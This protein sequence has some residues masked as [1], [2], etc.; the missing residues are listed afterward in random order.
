MANRRRPQAVVASLNALSQSLDAPTPGTDVISINRRRE[1]GFSL[2]ELLVIMSVIMIIGMI[3]VSQ[4]IMAYDRSRQRSTLADLR[5]LA[6][7]N[8]TY[9]VD[10]GNYAPTLSDVEPDY[11]DPAPPLDRWGFAWDYTYS[12]GK[13]SLRSHGSD[14]AAGPAPPLAWD[15]DPFECDLVVE[16]GAFVQVPTTD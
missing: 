13:Y 6:V 7:A 11:L 8:G 3:A 12:D 2:I 14:G 5:T 16:N 1:A 15:G 9:A 10:Q 4:F